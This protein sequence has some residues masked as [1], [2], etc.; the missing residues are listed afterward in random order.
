MSD[1]GLDTFISANWLDSE[2]QDLYFPEYDAP[3]TNN[4]VFENGDFEQNYNFLTKLAFENLAFQ[5]GANKREKGIPTGEYKTVF[6]D[7]RTKAIDRTNFVELKWTPTLDKNKNL[8]AKIYH[9]QYA[10]DGDWYYE[11]GT[12]SIEDRADRIRANWIGSEIQFDWETSEKNR[13]TLGGEYQNHY[14]MHQRNYDKGLAGTYTEYLND[15]H[16]GRVWSFYLQDIYKTAKNLSFI[17]GSRID[18]YSTFGKT[19]NPR[20][21]AVYNYGEDRTVKLLYGSAFRTPTFGDL[22]YHDGYYS[23][24]PNP[25]LKPE[26]LKTYELVYEQRIQKNITGILSLYQTNLSNIISQVD[27]TWGTKTLL[28]SQNTGK[29]EAKGVE[30]S[31]Q[32]S[33]HKINFRLASNHQEAKNK[34]TNQKLVNSPTNSANLGISIPFFNEGFYVTTEFQYMGKRLTVKEGEWLDSYLSTNLILF[35]NNLRPD[36]EVTLKVN[37]LF[38]ESYADPASDSYKQ[39][40]IPQNG[41]NYLL[42]IGYKF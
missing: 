19:I 16:K 2:G 18:S 12:N 14:K 40:R 3:E 1:N 41:R 36:M 38:N 39:T 28:Q 32:G 24:M 22:Y 7:P 42:K 25:D 30:L 21:G 11:K 15:K 20:I 17:L 4:G 8:L 26:K 34:T 23:M 5:A 13:V 33:W 31:V 37:N 27:E 29:V 10:L 35:N 6:N 9:C